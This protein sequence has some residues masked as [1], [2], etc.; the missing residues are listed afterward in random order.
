MDEQIQG[1]QIE[2][3]TAPAE[4]DDVAEE[5]TEEIEVE[6]DEPIDEEPAPA[7]KQKSEYVPLSKHMEMRNKWK[8]ADKKLKEIERTQIQQQAEQSKTSLKKELID[9]GWPELEAEIQAS[10]EVRR[11][12]EMEEIRSK[13]VDA[14]IKELA[15]SDGYFADAM[16]FKPEI[17]EKMRRFN[18]DAEDAYRLVRG[19]TR[20]VEYRLEQ[21]QRAAV[22]RRPA[23]AKKVATAT[24][25]APKAQ[26]P[27]DDN[28]RKALAGLQKAMPEAEWTAKKYF[29]VMKKE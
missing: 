17:R 12:V 14:D 11:H 18:C 13:L 10:N 16:A 5:P 6:A 4:V 29:E 19:K 24:P 3:V 20:D 27:L 25:S 23:Q 9:R 7:T 26:Y 8:E 1:E 21:E 22:K 28:D 2:Q 15:N